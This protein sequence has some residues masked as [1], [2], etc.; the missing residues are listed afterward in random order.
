VIA[1]AGPPHCGARRQGYRICRG[2]H[3]R[4]DPPR[5][6]G[7][8]GEELGAPFDV[9]S[10]GRRKSHCLVSWCLGGDL[11]H[12][13]WSLE[14]WKEGRTTKAPRAQRRKKWRA[15]ARPAFLL[16]CPPCLRG[17]PQI[18]KKRYGMSPSQGAVAVAAEELAN[19][20]AEM[21]PPRVGNPGGA[22][23]SRS[24]PRRYGMIR[25]VMSLRSPQSA[26]ER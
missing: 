13:R 12:C 18:F 14:H 26:G 15:F 22:P 1:H 24:L 10:R 2:T 3:S 23:L 7:G 16:P 5:R 19:S 9:G 6:R 17:D 20:I 4:K 21:R 8:H 11:L 25:H